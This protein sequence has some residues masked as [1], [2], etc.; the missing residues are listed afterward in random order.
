MDPVDEAPST[1][2][3]DA[4]DASWALDA[5]DEPVLSPESELQDAPAEPGGAL[6]PPD[7]APGIE[8]PA[9][10]GPDAGVN[11]GVAVEPST[12]NEPVEPVIHLEPEP[13]PEP[14]LEL[15]LEPQ[16]EPEPELEPEM[17]PADPEG[18]GREQP[19]VS[20]DRE[21]PA[22]P[23]QAPTKKSKGLAGFL[24]KRGLA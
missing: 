7:E 2:A 1:T 9:V 20:V 11:P 12:T 23:P 22:A 18:E 4:P 8:P 13:E 24:A 19:G 15:E 3:L 14:E 16:L 5:E 10:A 6:L 21:E 17:P